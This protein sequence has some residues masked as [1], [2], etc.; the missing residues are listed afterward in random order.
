MSSSLLGKLGL[1]PPG[2]KGPVQ[3]AIDRKID[4]KVD[5]LIDDAGKKA[6]QLNKDAMPGF[7]VF[8]EL[9]PEAELAE[10][11]AKGIENAK[12]QIEFIKK[13]IEY[14]EKVGDATAL[15]PL[16]EAAKNLKKV[17]D[18]VLAGLGKAAKVAALGKEVVVF[19]QALKRFADAS[20]TMSASQG[21]SV[22]AWVGTLK[23]LWNASKPFVDR[24]KDEAFTAA[25]AGSE[26]AGAL[27]ATL[28]IV[29]AELYVGIQVL[30][31]G[32][33]NV[34]A[35]FKR[36][37]DATREDNDRPV[38]RPAP[39]Q[40]PFPFQTRKETIASIKKHDAEEK[41]LALLREKNRTEAARQQTLEEAKEA[42]D[43]TDFPLTYIKRKYRPAILGKV[44]QAWRSSKGKRDDVREWWNCFI[45]DSPVD[46]DAPP[47]S[48]AEVIPEPPPRKI[49]IDRKDAA[50]EVR[51][52]LDVSPS[53]PFFNAIYQGEL[54]TYLAKVGAGGG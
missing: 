33:K 13:T 51:R 10:D 49:D 34:N 47:D 36:L 16:A 3:R 53:C 48:D 24:I 18:G 28:A 9:S 30:D 32:V 43:T 42:F 25:L 2:G 54:K 20:E 38:V 52:F 1:P 26:A 8:D 27:G 14:A 21:A 12:A 5:D 44:A 50:D 11:M 46:A 4:K 29:G 41:G 6:R 23:S 37:D 31:A 19:F 7:E 45:D 17:S 35:Y 22:E 39:P 40:A 15:K